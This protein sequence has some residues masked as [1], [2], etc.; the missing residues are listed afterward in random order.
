LRDWI[1]TVSLLVG[2]LGALFA[3]FRGICEIKA[4]TEQ[5]KEDLRWKRANAAKELLSEIHHHPNASNAV[6]MMDWSEGVHE[7]QIGNES[8]VIKYKDVLSILGKT[9]DECID[10]I[11]R[12]VRDSF[13]WFFYN[14]DQIEHYIRSGLIDFQDVAPVFEPYAKKI[15]ENKDVYYRFMTGCNYNL[16]R[17]FW[18]RYGTVA[19]DQST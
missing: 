18:K 16:A 14:I 2:I 15:R 12:F 13:D 9:Q 10:L 4:S 3:A 19:G 6:M 1:Q 17:Q 5:R 7:Y 11:Q 8:H